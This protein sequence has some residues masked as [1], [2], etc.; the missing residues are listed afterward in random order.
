MRCLGLQRPRRASLDDLRLEVCLVADRGVLALFQHDGNGC[1]PIFVPKVDPTAKVD[2][3]MPLGIFPRPLARGTPQALLR[4][5]MLCSQE[6]MAL[7]LTS[8]SPQQFC[9]TWLRVA[10][11]G[12]VVG[13]VL[14]A[15]PTTPTHTPE[16]LDTYTANTLLLAAALAPL[17]LQQAEGRLLQATIAC[18]AL[19]SAPPAGV[20]Y[21]PGQGFVAP[22]SCDDGN[23]GLVAEQLMHML[24]RTP[25]PVGEDD[26]D[27]SCGSL[28]SVNA[29]PAKDDDEGQAGPSNKR[30]RCAED[31][32]SVARDWWDDSDED[33][34]GGPSS[35]SMSMRVRQRSDAPKNDGSPST[36]EGASSCGANG[37]DNGKRCTVAADGLRYADPVM[38]GRFLVFMLRDMATVKRFMLLC[39]FTVLAAVGKQ[40]CNNVA[41]LEGWEAR[42]FVLLSLLQ[43]GLVLVL[44]SL[45]VWSA[46]YGHTHC[47]GCLFE[48]THE[49]GPRWAALVEQVTAM[50]YLLLGVPNVLLQT[51]YSFGGY[52]FYDG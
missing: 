23:T 46:R 11:C 8:T 21:L 13:S 14:V 22:A 28:D 44:H 47:G 16:Q 32:Q 27:S 52:I 36:S 18:G 51:R 34:C 24:S 38:E 45:P 41:A 2:R 50:L 39:F 43:I 5:P 15:V 19:G 30:Q 40:L 25:E 17:V 20:T 31:A 37:E 3:N 12:P 49:N 26:V 42:V 29:P 33:D 7:L 48:E 35:H 4:M 6:A 9:D 1:G 10:Q